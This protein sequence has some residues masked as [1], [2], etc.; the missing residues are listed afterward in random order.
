[1]RPAPFGLDSAGAAISCPRAHGMRPYT[2]APA[3]S[4]LYARPVWVC[5]VGAAI[6]RPRTY[7]MRPYASFHCKGIYQLAAIVSTRTYPPIICW[8]GWTGPAPLNDEKKEGTL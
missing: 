5:F 2:C 6:S 8:A 7:G 1:M 3:R 4:T